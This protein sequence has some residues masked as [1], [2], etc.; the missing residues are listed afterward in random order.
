M[1]VS[2]DLSAVGHAD[3]AII[4]DRSP[5]VAG[6]VFD[7]EKPQTDIVYQSSTSRYC[8]NWH[9]FND[10]QS[11]IGKMSQI[12]SFTRQSSWGLCQVPNIPN[13]EIIMEVGV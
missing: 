4:V 1:H 10:P 9:G 2:V 8:A 11:G 12:Y 5:P 7:G 3:R 13:N 6:L